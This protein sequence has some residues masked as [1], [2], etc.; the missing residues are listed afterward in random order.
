MPRRVR[1][2]DRQHDGGQRSASYLAVSLVFALVSSLAIAGAATAQGRTSVPARIPGLPRPDARPPWETLWRT[3]RHDLIGNGF[4][5]TENGLLVWHRLDNSRLHRWHN[6]HGS[7]QSGLI[8]R[9]NDER[10]Q[11]E[12]VREEVEAQLEAQIEA[13]I[14]QQP[15]SSR[16]RSRR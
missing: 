2:M 5:Q 12:I 9:S 13:L 6:H 11:F 14:E 15:D 7:Q 4:Q 8:E 16:P 1:G 10:F 3:K